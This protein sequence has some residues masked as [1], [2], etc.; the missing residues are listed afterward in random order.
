M[1]G[2]TPVRRRDQSSVDDLQVPY[3]LPQENGNR[4]DTRWLELAG[5]G[6]GL[7]IEGDAPFEFTASHHSAAQLWEAAHT[8]DLERRPETFLCIDA[9]QRGLGTATC[10]P[11]TLER[12]RID[13]NYISVTEKSIEYWCKWFSKDRKERPKGRIWLE[14]GGLR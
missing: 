4:C 8:V 3:V 11:D 7:R 6:R 1:E 14:S 12:Y 2:P 13:P 5:A 9:A 10:G